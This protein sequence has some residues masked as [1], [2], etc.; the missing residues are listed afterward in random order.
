MITPQYGGFDYKMTGEPS[1]P[2]SKP[3]QQQKVAEF[4]Q[5]PVITLAIQN[6]YYD[7]GK[8]ADALSEINEFDPDEF[9][10]E[11]TGGYGEG[12]MVDETQLLELANR[13]NEIMLKGKRLEPTA[14]ATRTHT[15]VH[16]AF[17]SSDEFK[18]AV[19]TNRE[20]LANFMYHCLGEEKAQQI[21]GQAKGGMAQMGGTPQNT[22]SQG[23]MQ[24]EAKATMPG[25]MMGSE[26][27]P[28]GQMPK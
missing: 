4:M 21:R 6:G 10:T 14:Y 3:L 23:I 12:T 15:D 18:S 25:K 1:F 27:A 13:E 22:E 20:I 8:M 28:S 16:L 5:H 7:V 9:K 24:G 17:M 26:L 11:E 19:Q 2:I